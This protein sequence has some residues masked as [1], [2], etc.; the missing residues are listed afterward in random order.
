M[1]NSIAEEKK[2]VD[3]GYWHLWRYDPTLKEE[4]KNPFILDSKEPTGTVREFLEGE[5]RY[6]MLKQT[7]PDVAEELFDKAEKDLLERYENYKR[8]AST[9]E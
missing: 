2:A 4:G 8:M 6:L 3:T 9:G 5:G 7:F 1:A